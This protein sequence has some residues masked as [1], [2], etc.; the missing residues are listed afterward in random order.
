[1]NF[2]LTGGAGFIGSHLVEKLI[3]DNH[4]VICVDDL[5]TG[6]IDCLPKDENLLFI[7]EKIQ[8]HDIL[9]LPDNVNG[10]LHLA[11]QASVPLSIDNFFESSSNNILGTLKV[12]SLAKELSIPLVYAVSSAIRLFTRFCIKRKTSIFI[13]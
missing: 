1:L 4:S 13:F 9:K 6:N 3:K 7:N 12:F 8:N 10:I 2:L 5:S 11:S